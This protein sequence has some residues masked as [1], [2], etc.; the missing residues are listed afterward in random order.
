M[1]N[2]FS[3]A[4]R[5]SYEVPEFLFCCVSNY[6]NR[7]INSPNVSLFELYRVLSIPS[8][9]LYR[10]IKVSTI[11][12]LF[13]VMFTPAFVSVLVRL[14]QCSRLIVLIVLNPYP[15][16]LLRLFE[17][18]NCFSISVTPEVISSIS[19]IKKHRYLNFGLCN[20]VGLL[21]SH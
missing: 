5:K 21:H 7:M 8:H 6:D 15:C 4:E 19:E 3:E 9:S 2:E 10:F 20:S 12:E 13:E 14:I 1:S 18:S 11:E 17:P 16:S